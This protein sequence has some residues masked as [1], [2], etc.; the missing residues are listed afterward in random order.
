MGST[1]FR[2]IDAVTGLT[3]QWGVLTNVAAGSTVVSFP[4][5]FKNV[6]VFAR[7]V[8][9]NANGS[10]NNADLVTS[11]LPGSF[12]FY[13]NYGVTISYVWWFALGY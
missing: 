11:L 12:T 9:S 10:T 4:T 5:T 8:G 6:C 3:L 13:M 1:G 7:A 2:T